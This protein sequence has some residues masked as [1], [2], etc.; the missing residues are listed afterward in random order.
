MKSL[1]SENGQAMVEYATLFAAVVIVAVI[2]F[3]NMSEATVKIFNLIQ[4]SL[5]P[6]FP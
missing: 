1:R 5:L 3:G 2:T 6:V 4:N